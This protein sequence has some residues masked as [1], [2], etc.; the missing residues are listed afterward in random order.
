MTSGPGCR[1]RRAARPDE[2]AA[3]SMANPLG[4]HAPPAHVG[5]STAGAPTPSL[6]SWAGTTALRG[7]TSHAFGGG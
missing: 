5:M 6:A 1:G 4:G 7:A 3:R 2:A